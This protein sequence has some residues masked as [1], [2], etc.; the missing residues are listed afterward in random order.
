MSDSPVPEQKK[1]AK[2]FHGVALCCNIFTFVYYAVAA[3]ATI[4][5]VGT[6]LGLWLRDDDD[7]YW[8][9]AMKTAPLVTMIMAT[10]TLSARKSA[11]NEHW[12]LN[13]LY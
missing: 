13:Q 3:V 1:S 11:T 8:G 5:T 10:M 2:A 6:V 12:I 7:Y 4:V 9:V